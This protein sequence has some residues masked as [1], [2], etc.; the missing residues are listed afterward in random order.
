[1]DYW[2]MTVAMAEIRYEPAAKIRRCEPGN[3]FMLQLQRTR[4]VI[5]DRQ[6]M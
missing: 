6:A 4:K 1:M 5:S 3:V 2:Q